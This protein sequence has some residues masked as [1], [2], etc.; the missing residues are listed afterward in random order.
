[1]TGRSFTTDRPLNGCF[2]VCEYFDKPL[3]G[4]CKKAGQLDPARGPVRLSRRDA[5]FRALSCGG[6]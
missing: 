4:Q 2:D 6:D 1:M 5:A 3:P